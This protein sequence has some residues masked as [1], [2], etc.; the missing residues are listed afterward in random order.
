MCKNHMRTHC[1]SGLSRTSYSAADS[2]TEAEYAA[3]EYNEES[4]H[5]FPSC[6][7]LILMNTTKLLP[8]NIWTAQE[9]LKVIHFSWR[10]IYLSR[11]VLIKR[12]FILCDL[13]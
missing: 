3:T 8:K 9:D 12:S 6:M 10:E 4:P 11:T 13:L 5:A 7:N 2:K 1:E